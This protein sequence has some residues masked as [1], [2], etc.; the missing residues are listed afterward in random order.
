MDSE[1]IGF[2]PAIE[3]AEL[4]RTKKISPVESMRALLDR[5]AALEPKVNA[6]AYLGAEQAMDGARRNEAQLMS[7]ARI[8]RLHGMPVTIKDLLLDQRHADAERQQDFAGDQPGEDTPIVPRL[9]DEGAIV[10]GKTTTS[11]FGWNGVWQSPLTGITSNPWKH[12]RMLAHPRPERALR[13]R[14]ALGRCI[15]AA[16]ARDRSACPRISAAYSG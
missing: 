12:G 15:K 2:M 10:I 4:I 6:F 11:E 9:Q 1:T 13:R 16:T 3:L 8:G 7:G 5:I 14:R